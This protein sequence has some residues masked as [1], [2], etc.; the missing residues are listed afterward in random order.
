MFNEN[1]YKNYIEN[2]ENIAEIKIALAI[3]LCVALG[4][5]IN[6]TL[7]KK[8]TIIIGVISAII[9]L[10]LGYINYRKTIIKTEEMKM[11]LDLYQKIM[12]M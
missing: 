4:I 2:K 12:N 11:K 7:L 10:I 5:I 8:D 3:V 6:R 9:G 1:K